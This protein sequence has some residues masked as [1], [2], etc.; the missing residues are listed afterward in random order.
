[1]LLYVIS[2][3]DTLP[4]VVTPLYKYERLEKEGYFRGAMN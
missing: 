3:I 4:Q 2:M 1:M